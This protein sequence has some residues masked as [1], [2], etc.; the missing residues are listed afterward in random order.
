MMLL[1]AW[2]THYCHSNGIP[3]EVRSI[4]RYFAVCIHSPTN[5]YK[6]SSFIDSVLKASS[7]FRRTDRDTI[8]HSGPVSYGFAFVSPSSG[9]LRSRIHPR[10]VTRLAGSP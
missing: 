2:D 10:L 3:D 5:P 1:R 6:Y 7:D 4:K 8:Y 9:P